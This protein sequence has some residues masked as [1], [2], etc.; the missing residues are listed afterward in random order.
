MC[1]RDDCLKGLR[2]VRVTQMSCDDFLMMGVRYQHR[3]PPSPDMDYIALRVDL[4]DTRSGSV[5]QVSSLCFILYLSIYMYICFHILH[6]GDVSDVYM[7]T[8]LCE[9]VLVNRIILILWPSYCKNIS[10]DVFI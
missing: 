1:R 2:L 7:Y 10:R 5:Y 3:D 8:L 9:A 4:R 6:V